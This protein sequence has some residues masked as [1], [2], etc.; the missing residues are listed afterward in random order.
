MLLAEGQSQEYGTQMTG[1]EQGW[2]PRKLRDPDHVDERRAAVG[3]GPVRE[4]AARI[5]R[6]QGPPRPASIACRECGEG[7]D[8]WLPDEGKARNVRCAACGWTTTITVGGPP[9]EPER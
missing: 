7:I 6:S 9:G 4:Y 2:A 5:N 3:L 1:G 8:V